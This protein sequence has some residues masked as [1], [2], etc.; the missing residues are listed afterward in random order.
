MRR[1]L[2]PVAP[3][4]KIFTTAPSII[5]ARH[6]AEQYDDDIVEV[7]DQEQAVVKLEV[8]GRHRHQHLMPPMT[9]VRMKP[10]DHRTAT[11]KRTRPP[12]IVG[13]IE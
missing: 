9:K 8:G 11:V 1:P 6:R 3:R 10:M 7:R 2:L 12:Y 13:L 5:V 4:R